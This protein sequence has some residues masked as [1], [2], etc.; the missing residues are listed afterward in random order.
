MDT[1]IPSNDADFF[2]FGQTERR[3]QYT[4]YVTSGGDIQ[5][6]YGYMLGIKQGPGPA[7][8]HK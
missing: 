7:D 1:S 3:K 6:P 2:L 5:G 8:L 4:D